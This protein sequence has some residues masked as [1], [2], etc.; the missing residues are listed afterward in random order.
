M[1]RLVLM[2][3]AAGALLLTI[4]APGFGQAPE[5]P[6]NVPVE[7]GEF[8]PSMMWRTTILVNDFEPS[9]ALYRDVLGM[10]VAYDREEIAFGPFAEFIG[11]EPD[12]SFEM[13]LLR[14]GDVNVGLIG[15]LRPTGGAEFEPGPVG[16]GV[17]APLLFFQT[18][19]YA[20]DVEEIRALGLEI[21]YE[22]E[23]SEEGRNLGP[24]LA[25]DPSGVR[26]GLTARDAFQLYLRKTE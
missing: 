1:I 12:Q 17:G 6:R 26:F 10:T 16:A 14:S 23:I 24:F 2:T 25:T 7:D 3:C 15:L 11:F 8:G 22:P 9:L 20:E 4:A 21:F 18:T 19:D 13:V 5:G